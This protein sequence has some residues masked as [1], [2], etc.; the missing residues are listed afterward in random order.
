MKKFRRNSK[1]MIG[2][3][4]EGLGEYI[5]IDPVLVRAI[6]VVTSIFTMFPIIA[7]C[8]MWAIVPKN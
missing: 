1:Q 5:N 7:Y 6:F 3:V 4:C 8:I 2:G